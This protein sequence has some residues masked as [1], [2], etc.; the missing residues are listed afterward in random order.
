MIRN[1]LKFVLKTPRTV[2]AMCAAAATAALWLVKPVLDAS[3]SASGFPVDYATGQLAFDGN[4]LKGYYA[5]MISKRTLGVYWQTQFID[6]GFIAAVF[7]LGLFVATGVA[8]L[9]A[10]GSW[11]RRV[12]LLSAQAAMAGALFDACENLVSFIMLANPADFQNGIALVYS[13]F[14]ASKFILILS[15]MIG[16]TISLAACLFGRIWLYAKSRGTPPVAVH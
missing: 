16:T 6:F 2:H 15:A 12:G 3:Y 10:P 5:H 9:S 14:A 4:L 1:T 7:C 11:G 8:R 13:T